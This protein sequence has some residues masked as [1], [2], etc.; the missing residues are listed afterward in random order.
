MIIRTTQKADA[1]LSIVD[2]MTCDDARLFVF[3]YQ[4][5]RE[6]G[7]AVHNSANDRVVA[8]AELAGSDRI[9]VYTGKLGE[10]DPAGNVPDE[11][12]WKGRHVI[13]HDEYHL[14]A[15]VIVAHLLDEKL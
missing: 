9:V 12:V 13:E 2:H 3:P 14:A 11:D 5:G 15:T 6:H 1:I 8:F 10:F 7:W 4:N